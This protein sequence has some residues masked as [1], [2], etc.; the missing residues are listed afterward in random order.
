[1]SA[2]V[3][4]G[5]AVQR[6]VTLIA[7]RTLFR[8]ISRVNIRVDVSAISLIENASL[9]AEQIRHV[10]AFERKLLHLVFAER[11]AER[12]VSRVQGDGL[13]RDLHGLRGDADFK[14][15][16]YSG[17]RVHKQL[18]IF[19][20]KVPKTGHRH[21]QR[22]GPRRQSKEFVLAGLSRLHFALD[23]LSRADERHAS[24]DD[25]STSFIRHYTANRRSTD[26]RPYTRNHEQNR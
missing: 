18:D 20:L 5:D 12:S 2:R 16:V 11:N 19:V 9:Q 17:R 8:S 21:G 6:Y 26:L 3:V 24:T 22:V 4:H 10:A 23:R 7:A 14:C 1:M 15:G 25:R 13:R